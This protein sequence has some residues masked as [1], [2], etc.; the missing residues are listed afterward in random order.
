[1]SAGDTPH[2]A[3]NLGDHVAA[4]A[5]GQPDEARGVLEQ[6]SPTVGDDRQVQFLRHLEVGPVNP[7]N[8]VRDSIRHAMRLVEGWALSA[9]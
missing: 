2:R 6:H 3:G 7:G 1:M 4:R 5:G 8:V 9:D